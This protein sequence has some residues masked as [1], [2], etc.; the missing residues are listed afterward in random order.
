VERRDF[1][2]TAAQN[3]YGGEADNGL[4][5]MGE[6]RYMWKEVSE[7]PKPM[8]PLAATMSAPFADAFAQTLVPKAAV[9]YLRVSTRDQAYRGGESEGFSIPA[10]REANRRKA[11]SLGAIIIKEFVDRGA[12]A[13]TANRPELQNMLEYVTEN[14]V[15]YVIVHKVDRL[16]RNREDDV[17]I[18]KALGKAGVRLVSTTE[19]I[20]ETPSG[21]LLHGIMSSIAE[22]YSR[23]LA[24]EVVKG[25]SQ[26][27]QGGGTISKAPLG[28]RNIRTTDSEGR[29][30]RTVALDEE[31]APLMRLAFELY[32]TGNWTLAALADHLADRGLTTLAT[33][34]V[35]SVPID[36]KK[37]NKLLINPYYKG[38]VKFRDAYHPGKHEALIDELTWQKVQSVLAAHANGE[39]DRKHPHYLRGTVFCGTC[40]ARLGIHM[41]QARGGEIY[42]YFVCY[43]RQR[44]RNSCNQK[45]VLIEDVEA[46][47]EAQYDRIALKPELRR[48]VE[49]MLSE[50]L[51]SASSDSEA[52]M[53][54]LR[55]EREKLER[56]RDKLMEA[57]YE[58]A[59]PVDLLRREQERI[60]TS[61]VNI[62][63]KLDAAALRYDDIQSNLRTALDLAED[64][65]R[66]YRAAPDDVRRQFNQVFFKRV[67]VHSDADPEIEL[68][69]PFDTLLSA[70]VRTAVRRQQT[71]D[72]KKPTPE[73]GLLA[74]SA[75]NRR[76]RPKMA[77]LL[78]HGSVK[79][80]LV[81]P[82]GIEPLT[83]WLPA[84]RSPS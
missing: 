51:R 1:D 5:G 24:N 21:M 45:A 8:N 74:K 11:A 28:Y 2:N 17:E 42:P 79:T 44:S 41:T 13:K 16:A 77:S 20:D 53:Q 61:L 62:A 40:G 12:S 15:D 50:E 76:V 67:L 3:V 80:L 26:K 69:P 33:P 52:Q 66:A 78:A 84:K 19:S 47:V 54:S 48:S 4:A 72:A 7:E 60:S 32:A 64:C 63:S 14:S 56:Q 65:G 9:S 36:G 37:L 34:R 39:R 46:Q 82:R 27:V 73:S 35:A 83:S 29:E 70:E 57:H 75:L 23:N 22:F 55:R 81:E 10:Q 71:E 30:F 59:V 68:A 6:Q 18:N 38:L 58:G 25:M 49:A 43:G 31:R